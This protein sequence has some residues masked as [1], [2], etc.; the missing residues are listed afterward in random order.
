MSKFCKIFNTKKAS[1]F[2]PK[3]TEA[4][5][6]L[7][8]LIR[9]RNISGIMDYIMKL[10]KKDRQKIS[11]E[12]Y[13]KVIDILRTNEKG[14]NFLFDTIYYIDS[15]TAEYNKKLIKYFKD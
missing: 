4:E 6:I 14:K 10:P 12:T 9:N 2:S 7:L 3:I 11:D 8:S 1:W 5:T 15:E 13:L